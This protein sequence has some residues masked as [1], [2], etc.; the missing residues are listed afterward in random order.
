MIDKLRYFLSRADDILCDYLGIDRKI[1]DEP[2]LVRRIGGR[3]FIY[4]VCVHRRH[5]LKIPWD[6]L[7]CMDVESLSPTT[8]E[9]LGL[10]VGKLTANNLVI[11]IEVN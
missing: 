3:L 9:K 11:N 8:R 7:T 5:L 10:A 6:N 2:V 1:L 4:V